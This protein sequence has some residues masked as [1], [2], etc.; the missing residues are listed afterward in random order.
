MLEKICN[1]IGVSG[2]ENDIIQSLYL[3]LNQSTENV[4]YIDKTGNLVYKQNGAVGNQKIMICAHID[5]VGFQVIK[6]INDR[7][8]RIKPL[9]NVKTWNAFQQRVISNNSIGV[10]YAHDESNLKAH[11]FDNLFLEVLND[12][13]VNIGDIFTFDSRLTTSEL[14][15]TGKALDNRIAC[16]LL[17]NNICSK[18]SSKADVYYVFTTQEE[19]GMRGIRYAKSTIKP[20]FVINID[21][22][23]ENEMSSLVVGQGVGIKISDSLFV[24]SSESVEWIKHLAINNNVQYQMEVSDCGTN[25]LIISNEL[26]SGYKELGISIPCKYPHTANT[27]VAKKDTQECQKLLDLIL[28]D[29]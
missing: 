4:A 5:E 29:L 1:S 15:Y 7:S 26:D 21:S 14:F 28:A 13:E 3:E 23:P 24:S 11:N 8:Y 27:L 16:F 19:I 20:D 25:E 17:F 12:S 9:G 6:P 2:Y 22:S 10:I 18:I